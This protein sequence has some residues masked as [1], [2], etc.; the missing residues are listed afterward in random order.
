MAI[1]GA[2][3]RF[4][5]S[6]FFLFFY[7][8]LFRCSFGS[9]KK[10]QYPTTKRLQYVSIGLWIRKRKEKK[11]EKRERTIQA[12]CVIMKVCINRILKWYIRKRK[13]ETKVKR[14]IVNRMH[15]YIYIYIYIHW[16]L[17]CFDYLNKMCKIGQWKEKKKK[18]R[19]RI[20]IN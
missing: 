9:E 20:H 11:R 2:S 12:V 3:F 18:R 6:F 19:R 4:F 17:A 16:S 8:I 13:I 7:S 1:H 5:F 15:T 14:N 10:W